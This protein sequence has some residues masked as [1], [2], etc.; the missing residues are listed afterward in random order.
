MPPTRELSRPPGQ[1]LLH[2]LAEACRDAREAD[3]HPPRATLEE[4]AA[5]AGVGIDTVRRFE[6]ARHWPGDIDGLVA[7]YAYECG[8]EDGRELYERALERW[9]RHGGRPL[10][11]REEQA[12]QSKRPSERVVDA[13]KRQAERDRA[14]EE[15]G[16]KSRPTRSKRRTGGG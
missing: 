7:A 12:R 16:A 3:N 9:R 8:L 11:W 15:R 14:P 1:R 10:T 5:A 2:W 6:K 4:V 13:V